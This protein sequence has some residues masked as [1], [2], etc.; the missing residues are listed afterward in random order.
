MGR[1]VFYASLSLLFS[2]LPLFLFFRV[3]SW[4]GIMCEGCRKVS[5]IILGWNLLNFLSFRKHPVIVTL[6]QVIVIDNGE[7]NV[8]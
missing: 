6:N 4:S 7:A 8:C 2:F 1:L 3:V 5:R